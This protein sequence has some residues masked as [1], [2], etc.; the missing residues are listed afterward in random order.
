VPPKYWCLSARPWGVTF[1]V[2]VTLQD[3]SFL[4]WCK[5][6]L[7]FCGMWCCVI[8]WGGVPPFCGIMV[9]LCLGSSYSPLECQDLFVQM[10]QLCVP[11]DSCHSVHCPVNLHPTLTVWS[12][13][14]KHLYDPHVQLWQWQTCTLYV[15]VCGKVSAMLDKFKTYNSPPTADWRTVLSVVSWRGGSSLGREYCLSSVVFQ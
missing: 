8:G 13:P 11:A 4:Q 1:Y 5:W 9:L 15:W 6:Q 10:I 7:R 3:F 14:D 2:T 12:F